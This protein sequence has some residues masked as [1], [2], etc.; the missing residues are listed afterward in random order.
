M[1]S[2]VDDAHQTHAI[3]TPRLIFRSDWNAQDQVV[4]QYSHY[5][6]GNLVAVKNGYPPVR[7][8]TIVPDEDVVSLIATMWW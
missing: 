4:L 6:N 3:L 1:V 8:L 5:L 7:D 2:N